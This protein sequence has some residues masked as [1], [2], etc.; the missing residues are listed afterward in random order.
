MGFFLPGEKQ[1]VLDVTYPH[2]ADL[3]ET[4]SNPT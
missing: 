3:Q 1:S 2:R 4:L